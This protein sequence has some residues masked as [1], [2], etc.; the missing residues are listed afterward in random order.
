LWPHTGGVVDLQ[1]LPGRGALVNAVTQAQQVVGLLAG[2]A[3]LW[4]PSTGLTL[5]DLLMGDLGSAARGINAAGRIVGTGNAPSVLQPPFLDLDLAHA[6]LWDQGVS[7]DL[8][9]LLDTPGWSLY[10][11]QAINDGGQI[12]SLCDLES[13]AP[14]LRFP[15]HTCLLTPV[16]SDTP[17]PVDRPKKPRGPGKEKHE[18]QPH[19]GRG[20]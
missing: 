2:R 20:R 6:L 3:F 9:A 14:G 10:F 8:N 17:P 5:L 19:E 4:T 7:F 15:S 12:L 18:Q 1:T 16:A 11:A 13:A